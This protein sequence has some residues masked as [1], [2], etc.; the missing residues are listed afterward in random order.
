[1]SLRFFSI[2]VLLVGPAASADP[3]A[4]RPNI[5]FAISDDQSW[6][7][8]G[9]NG[10]FCVRTPAF[11]RIAREGVRFTR[12]FTAAPTCT[13]SRSAILTGQHIWRL[14]EGGLL[15]GAL[16]ARFKVFPRLL[17]DA[18]YF[19][20]YTGKS[21]GPGNLKAGG[22]EE[23]P[24]GAAYVKARL[25]PRRPG[26]SATDYA[27]NFGLFLKDRPRDKPFFFW[28]GS[29]EPHLGYRKGQ[30]LE[31]GKKLA[32][33]RF[34]RSLPDDP[35]V[36]GDVLDYTVEVEHFDRHLGR[37]LKQ[38]E[39]AGELDNTL[40]VVTSDH[41]MPLPRAKATL[42]DSG[43]RVP[44]AIRHP[45]RIP[46]GRTV[47]DFVSL[48]D[49][50]PTLLDFAGQ[51]LPDEMTGRS[52]VPILASDRSGRLAAD[53]DFVVTAMERHSWCRPDGQGYPMRAIRT[54]R[55]LYIRNFEPDRW[56]VGDPDFQSSHQGTYG[57]YDRCPT[58][59]MML[60]RQNDPKIAPLFRIGYGKR[61]AEEL[62]DVIDDPDQLKNLSAREDFAAVRDRLR[63]RLEDYLRKTEDP[64]MS[65]KAEWDGMPYYFRDYWKRAKKK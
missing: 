23:H 62:Y 18:G 39:R 40:V 20:G 31:A 4:D 12:S 28:Y 22:R 24:V 37:I 16:P 2:L 43:T 57:D 42:Y 48:T 30:G 58:K 56:P 25:N 47:D 64:R 26:M 35:V 21:W 34:Y 65:G 50:A 14:E 46:G 52:L 29:F 55:F 59:Q 51:A 41:G 15:F 54:E 61:P 19:I 7:N 32:D 60:D 3:T 10:D 27:A 53:R 1:M 17:E 63:R 8:T 33:A 11:D 44:L 49:I 9:A 38:L 5:L 6:I 36:R 13:P 45:G